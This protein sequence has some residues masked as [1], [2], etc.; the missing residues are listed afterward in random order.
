MRVLMF[1]GPSTASPALSNC[2]CPQCAG[3]TRVGVLCWRGW[4]SC[5]AGLTDVL[6]LMMDGDG[7][8]KLQD[9]PCFGGRLI[10]APL[11][12]LNNSINSDAPC[13]FSYPEKISVFDFDILRSFLNST[14][15]NNPHERQWCTC[16]APFFYAVTCLVPMG[17]KLCLVL[18]M[19]QGGELCV[20]RKN[21]VLYPMI[22]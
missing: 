14:F 19:E 15:D 8:Q 3:D 22:D 6:L 5:S 20:D 18:E 21:Y 10:V 11:V 16:S 12:H 7:L 1:R 17:T 9:T 4:T 13:C 2:L